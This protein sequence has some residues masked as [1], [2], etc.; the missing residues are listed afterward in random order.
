MGMPAIPAPSGASN[1][2]T[3][4]LSHHIMSRFNEDLERVRA[5]V[6][7]MGGLVE[8]QLSNGLKA[9][10]NGDVRL[11]D[12]VANQDTRVNAMEVAIDEDCARILATRSP[13]A[14]DLRLIIAII[15]TITDLERIGDESQKLGQAAANMT[16]PDRL[17][18]RYREV[19]HLGEMVS[20]MLHRSLDAFARLD[21]DAALKITRQDLEVDQEYEALQRQCITFMME[22]PRTIRRSLDLLWIARALER[23]GD[24][25]KNIC[26]YVVFMVLGKD[27]RHLPEVEVEREVASARAATG[28]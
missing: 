23:V 18:E 16:S 14:S 17:P 19:R 13:T 7:Q 27:I 10:V 1:V 15:K 11:G 28:S 12:E 22:D 9:I 6:L 2:E 26:E 4:E 25:S 3:V 8:Q 21:A 20:D 5:A 24:H